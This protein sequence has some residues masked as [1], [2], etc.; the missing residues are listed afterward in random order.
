M[1]LYVR[2]KPQWINFIRDLQELKLFEENIIPGR[3]LIIGDVSQFTTPMRNRLLK[4]LEEHS[5]IQC[6]SS[7]DITDPILLS[8]FIKIT[9]EPINYIRNASIE[10]FMES[11]RD[12]TATIENMSDKSDNLKLR[13]RKVNNLFLPMLLNLK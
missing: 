6:Y 7:E 10:G 3:S 8:R 1:I 9:K 5:Y 12:Y 11:D 2:T 4:L 13:L